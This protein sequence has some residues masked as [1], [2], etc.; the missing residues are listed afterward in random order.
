[1][2]RHKNLFRIEL[3]VKSRFK[4]Y[5]THEQKSII[6]VK[7]DHTKRRKAD[8]EG[9]IKKLFVMELKALTFDEFC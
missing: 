8:E 6:T 1:M 9:Q 2:K 5:K 3:K 7:K 4:I